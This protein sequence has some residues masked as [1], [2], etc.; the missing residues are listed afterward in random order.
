V[1]VVT[2][3]RSRY[4]FASVLG[5][6]LVGFSVACVTSVA[7]AAG[8]PAFSTLEVLTEAPSAPPSAFVP[9]G[10]PA[11]APTAFQGPDRNADRYDWRAVFNAEDLAEDRIAG[12]PTVA[13]PLTAGLAATLEMVNRVENGRRFDA[14]GHRLD[15]VGYVL[16]KRDALIRAGLPS[17]AVSPAVVRTRGGV[18]HA[19]LIVTTS[20]GDQ[21]LDNLSPYVDPWRRV[22]YE[23]IKREV[24]TRDGRRW[25]WVG[26]VAPTTI[27][28]AARR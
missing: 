19:V 26:R 27:M 28:V 1:L 14:K 23:W 11:S 15:C 22:D 8:F 2:L 17:D 10:L 25:A 12:D 6:V 3:V 21:V 16:A 5:A 7:Q 24:A 13:L 9:V 4:R 20:E 18:V